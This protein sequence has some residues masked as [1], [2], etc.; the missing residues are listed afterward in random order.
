M[1]TCNIYMLQVNLFLGSICSSLGQFVPAQ[2]NLFQPWSTNQFVPTQVNLFLPR[3]ICSNLGQFVSTQVNYYYY[4]YYYY[5]NYN[6]GNFTLLKTIKSYNLRT[7]VN[8]FLQCTQVNL[9]STQVNLFFN[10]LR[11]IFF[12]LGQFVSAEVNLIQPRSICFLPWS[13]LFNLGQF[14]STY[15]RSICFNLGRFVFYLVSQ[16]VFYLQSI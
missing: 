15:S 9:F 4:Y 5:Y 10:Q 11:S 16:F 12:Y 2:V 6:N 3:S 7:Q 14:V 8:L 1:L 13:I